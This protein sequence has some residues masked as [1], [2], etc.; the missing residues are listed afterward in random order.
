MMYF[1]WYFDNLWWYGFSYILL[2]LISILQIE[3]S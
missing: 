3:K 1:I 2:K